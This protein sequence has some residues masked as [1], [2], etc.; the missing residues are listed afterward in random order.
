MELIPWMLSWTADEV[1]FTS[2]RDGEKEESANL[3]AG[4]EGG[5][6]VCQRQYPIIAQSL[7]MADGILR[8]LS[9][10]RYAKRR[11]FVR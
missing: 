10:S 7:N 2:C 5:Q 3:A 8:Q 9:D 11:L 6:A 4:K 1:P